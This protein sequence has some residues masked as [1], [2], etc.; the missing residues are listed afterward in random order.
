MV[1]KPRAA[2]ISIHGARIGHFAS[3]LIQLLDCFAQYF[4]PANPHRATFGIWDKPVLREL[5]PAIDSNDLI[6]CFVDLN[7]AIRSGMIRDGTFSFGAGGGIV[8][9][10]DPCAEWEELVLKA[11]AFLIALDVE[12]ESLTGERIVS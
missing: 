8:A 12:P 11:K 7:I 4:A 10:S 5:R 9:D 6:G 1:D 2:G 3:R